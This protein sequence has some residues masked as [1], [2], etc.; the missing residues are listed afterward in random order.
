MIRRAAPLP[1]HQVRFR[2]GKFGTN[3]E[4]GHPQRDRFPAPRPSDDLAACSMRI[5]AALSRAEGKCVLDLCWRHL[6]LEPELVPSATRFD[7]G[8]EV[9]HE[10][11]A[12][13]A[14]RRPPGGLGLD[15]GRCQ[16]VRQ[17]TMVEDP[18]QGVLDALAVLTQRYCDM[19]GELRRRMCGQRGRLHLGFGDIRDSM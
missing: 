15:S 13:K 12:V 17:P 3:L 1:S 4:P 11:A 19:A 5:L 10:E 18:R 14:G 2:Y 7:H 16:P 6:Y 8:I 9:T